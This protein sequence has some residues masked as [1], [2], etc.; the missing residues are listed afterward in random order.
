[1]AEGKF[2][3]VVVGGGIVGATAAF[4]L[5]KRGARV[6]LVERGRIGS[7][8]TR[9]SF[10][11]I[12]ATSKV[13]DEAY[14]RLNARGGALYKAFA[15]E[16]GAADLGL[17]DT[18]MLQCVNRGH[19]AGHAVMLE[20]AAY[21][22][23]YGYPHRLIGADELRA[24]EP[25]VV[26]EDDAE[27]IF[28]TA[29]DWVDAPRFARFLA[30]RLDAMGSTVFEDSAARRL[31]MTDDGAVAGIA[32]DQ[33]VLGAPSV[34][35]AAGPDTPEV[36]SELTG[37]DGFAAR[38]P[39]NRVP[40]L[41]LTT[42]PK[43]TTGRLKHIIYFDRAAEA[44]HVRPAANGGL[45]LG[46]E[47]ID[48]LVAEDQSAET[49]RAAAGRLLSRAKAQLS[50]IVGDVRLDDCD[51]AVGVRPYPL[52]GRTL[53]GAL[54]GSE[55]LYVIATHSGVT[56]APALGELMAEV[57]IDGGAP[58]ALAPFSLDRFPG[59]G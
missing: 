32:T 51:V 6:A 25:H 17:F 37:Y 30:A 54:P 2:D 14:H 58:E 19:A 20:Q 59:F 22:K 50:G 16:F 53:A 57:M 41:L 43:E 34:L 13:A 23:R 52:D 8:T 9:R 47:D 27:A 40:G 29:D 11:W 48:G 31:E 4:C 35:V 46:A 38:F 44:M 28:A 49:V 1:M 5:A 56:L 33:H 36:L 3:I 55:G 45:R 18:G 12:N 42:P 21:L 10:A 7:G 26:F 24:L 15:A 39:M